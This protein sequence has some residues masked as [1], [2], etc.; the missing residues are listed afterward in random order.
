MSCAC[1]DEREHAQPCMHLLANFQLIY[2]PFD[3]RSE[4]WN[5]LEL[6][7][8]WWE[9]I[10]K[11]ECTPLANIQLLFALRVCVLF[12]FLFYGAPSKNSTFE[13]YISHL[14]A[15]GKRIFWEVHISAVAPSKYILFKKVI[16]SNVSHFQVGVRIFPTCVRTICKSPCAKYVR[17]DI[18][19]REITFAKSKK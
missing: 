8:P 14:R 17:Q 7:Q 13:K 15:T 10:P 9:N 1:H 11:H 5:K 3:F 12:P 2:R 16:V 6:H 18:S 19:V 4:K